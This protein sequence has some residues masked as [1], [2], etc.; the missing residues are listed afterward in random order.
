MD[1]TRAITPA[2]ERGFAEGAAASEPGD[3]GSDSGGRDAIDG[4]AI[5]TG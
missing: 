4:D 1:L 2:I 5:L 3:T